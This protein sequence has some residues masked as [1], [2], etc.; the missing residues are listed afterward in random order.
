MTVK[1]LT[2]G[3]TPAEVEALVLASVE[4]AHADFTAR[5]LIELRNKAEADLRHAAKG[6]ATAGDALTASQRDRIDRATEAAPEPPSPATV[7]A[8][9]RAGDEFGAATEPLAEAVMSTVTKAVLSGK[10][11]DEVRHVRGGP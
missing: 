7:A 9:Q 5:R 10:R 4:H 1:A 6:L 3:L 2:H 8:L 11:E